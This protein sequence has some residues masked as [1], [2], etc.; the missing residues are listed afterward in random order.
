MEICGQQEE[1]L[2]EAQQNVLLNLS[3]RICSYS[4]FMLSEY[5]NSMLAGTM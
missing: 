1:L 4:I 2:G 3:V 5:F